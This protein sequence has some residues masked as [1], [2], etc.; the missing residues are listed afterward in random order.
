M[1]NV[2]VFHHLKWREMWIT[3]L[4][5]SLGDREDR[6]C[7]YAASDPIWLPEAS[8]LA[9][10]LGQLVSQK[11]I[12]VWTD[13][14]VRRQRKNYSA[15]P[16]IVGLCGL[17]FAAQSETAAAGIPYGGQGMKPI[18]QV[19]SLV[20]FLTTSSGCGELGIEC[21]MPHGVAYVALKN[22]FLPM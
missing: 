11:T 13:W 15:L 21:T 16:N 1:T 4:T 20:E 14:M 8:E 6:S 22:V 17:Y 2:E 3:Q 9:G 5:S 10:T 19:H 7:Y 12:Q 18:I